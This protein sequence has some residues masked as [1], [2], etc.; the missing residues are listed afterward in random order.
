MG[1]IV[2]RLGGV[3]TEISFLGSI[4]HLMGGSGLQ[5]LLELVYAKNSVCHMLSGKAIN[6]AVC[7][8]LLIDAA[9]NTILIA[10]SYN[11]SVPCKIIV[12]DTE[13]L[14]AGEEFDED[15]T[16][17]ECIKNTDLEKARE[18]YDRLF[19][20]IASVDDA[21]SSDILK[22]IQ[23]NLQMKKEGQLS[24]T[25]LL[26]LQYMT[27]IDILRMFLKAERT[28]NLQAV[29]DMLPYF[30]ASGHTL[31]AKSA[32]LYL[33]MMQELLQTHPDVYK[34]FQEGYHVVRRSN[35]YWAGLSTASISAITC[36]YK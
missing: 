10:D 2:L 23:N 3:H 22:Q 27:M 16:S 30:A 28:G 29:H 18:L 35:R 17:K 32:Y 8:H 24:H 7:A 14:N 12:R 4:G 34:I 19:S 31:Y 26:W 6:R 5:E 20:G 15:V 9:L 36:T 13:G 33:Q 21:C 1:N 11:V 25:A